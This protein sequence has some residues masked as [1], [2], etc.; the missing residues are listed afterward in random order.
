L[1]PAPCPGAADNTLNEPASSNLHHL[2]GLYS[3]PDVFDIAQFNSSKDIGL[4]S[5]KVFLESHVNA[6]FEYFHVIPQFN[7]LHKSSFLRDFH[8]DTLDPLILRCVCGIASRFIN[9]S[10]DKS[11]ISRWLE[12]VE[13]QIWSRTGEMKIQNLQLIVLLVCWYSLERKI[14]HMWTASAMATRMAYG[15]RLNHETTN[16]MPFVLR[17]SRRRLMWSIFMF[18]KMY[19]GGISELTLCTASTMHISLPCEERNFDLDIPIE[20][21]ALEPT[22]PGAELEAGIGIMGHIT[23]LLNIRHAILE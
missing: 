7:F 15:M 3:I 23:R 12:E 1:E 17:E 20:T 16:K 22:S 8:R 21:S 18:D 5:N 4:A 6:Y 10:S 11:Y 2:K 9:Q 19:S 14:S 13:A